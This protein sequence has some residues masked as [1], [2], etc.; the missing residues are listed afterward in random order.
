MKRTAL[1]TALL[2]AL[3][4]PSFGGGLSATATVSARIIRPVM[5]Q[6]AN[7]ASINLS[8]VDFTRGYV[9]LSDLRVGEHGGVASY[10]F[11]ASVA[12]S[13]TGVTLA[14]PEGSASN[15]RLPISSSP[16]EGSA[17]TTASRVLYLTSNNY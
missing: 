5:L 2:A 1:L 17:A 12:G 3:A 10:Q 4:F 11:A 16:V 15:A 6:V 9:D 14:G 8:G 13:A 7:A